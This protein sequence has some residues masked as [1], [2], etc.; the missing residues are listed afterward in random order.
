MRTESD[1]VVPATLARR[2][3]GSDPA[4]EPGETC[5]VIAP[6]ADGWPRP[7]LLS[8]GEILVVDGGRVVMLMLHAGGRTAAALE[9]SGR[10]L[11]VADADGGL[12][13]VR[14]ALRRVHDA[15]AER[16]SRM[17][18]RGEVADVE[19]DEVGYARVTHGI[20]YELADPAPVLERWSGQLDVLRTAA[21]R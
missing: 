20:G 18:L 10:G 4:R 15:A 12:V 5:L 19:R 2:Y 14:L 11:L 9:A 13:R 8:A 7:A 16:M 21:E 17:V 1:L 3:D 6:G